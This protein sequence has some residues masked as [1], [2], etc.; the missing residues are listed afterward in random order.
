M[1]TFGSAK[2][3]TLREPPS[4]GRLATFCWAPDAHFLRGGFHHQ[5]AYATATG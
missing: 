1:G 2:T 3:C 5:A 4:A